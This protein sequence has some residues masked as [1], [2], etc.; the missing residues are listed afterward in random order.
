M[1]KAC[2]SCRKSDAPS[3]CGLCQGALCR[4]CRIFL[5]DSAFPFIEAAPELKHAYYCGGC[6]DETVEPVKADY[7]ATLEQ[8]K[9]VYVIYKGSKSTFKSLRKADGGTTVSGSKDRDDTILWLA[10]HAA[11]AGFNAITEVEVESKKVRNAGWQSSVWT[12]S[13]V[14]ADIRSYETDRA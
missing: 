1:E 8:A 10:F 2:V 5:G 6:Y 14:P 3:E 11:K 9:G 13:G 4:K 7:E 12:G